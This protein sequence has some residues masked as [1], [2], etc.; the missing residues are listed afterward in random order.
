MG[1]S[2]IEGPLWDYIAVSQSKIPVVNPYSAASVA[3]PE[4]QEHR[5]MDILSISMSAFYF[6][7]DAFVDHEKKGCGSPLCVDL[8]LFRQDVGKSV[9][10]C[11]GVFQQ[12]YGEGE[13]TEWTL[14]NI[15]SLHFAKSDAG[16]RA[17][18]LLF[19][20]K[21]AEV[22]CETSVSIRME[23]PENH[24]PFDESLFT[25]TD[26]DPRG[27]RPDD[28]ERALLSPIPSFRYFVH[29]FEMVL[30]A[31]KHLGLLSMAN[32]LVLLD[33]LEC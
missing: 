2:L 28:E 25:R 23:I 24:P 8:V 27:P 33:G 6:T 20:A 1:G 14:E 5:R 13:T 10:L 3:R 17:T 29:D 11:K 22:E 19:D 21:A 7:C 26:L 31:S 32:V 4:I 9:C 18:R 12:F 15:A 30:T 16:N